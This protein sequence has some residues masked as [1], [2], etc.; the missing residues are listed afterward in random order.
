M[1]FFSIGYSL[2]K[3]LPFLHAKYWQMTALT[4]IVCTLFLAFVRPLDYGI[5]EARPIQAYADGAFQLTQTPASSWEVVDAFPNLTFID[6]V[7]I[8]QLEGTNKLWILGKTGFIWSVD[9]SPAVT[10][11]D[12]VMDITDLVDAREDAGLLGLA[13]HPEFSNADS[14]SK[15][16]IYV[17]YR[18]LPFT[19][20]DYTG[21]Q[22]YIRVSRFTYDDVTQTADPD[23]ELRLMNI[24]DRHDWH[25]GGGMFFGKDGFLY[26]SIGDEGGSR[27]GFNS[28]QKIDQSLFS[29][30]LR[31]DVDKDPTRSHPIRRQPQDVKI[32]FDWPVSSTQEYYIPNDN[33]W[34]SPDSSNL[35]EFYAIGLRS[36]FRMTYDPVEELIWIG[37]VGQGKREEV[38]IIRKGDNLQWPFR[39]GFLES[40]FAEKPENLL[41]QEHGPLYQYDRSI[42]TCVIGG[43]VYRGSK[44][45]SLQGKYIFGDH[46]NRKVWSMTYG[47][48][49]VPEI[50]TLT[51][52]PAGGEGDKSGIS[53]FGTDQNG[54]IYVLKLFG[55]NKDG[56]KV[57]KLQQAQDWEINAPQ[58]LAATGIFKDFDTMEPIS[59]FIPYDVNIPFWSD[60][61]EKNRWVAIP[62]NGT[63]NA[64]TERIV[65]NGDDGWVFP[66]G[67]VFIK[68]FELPIDKRNPSLTQKL[69]TRFMVVGPDQT[70]KGF[71]YKWNQAG[72]DAILLTDKVTQD[73]LITGE[74]G[75]PWVQTWEYPS[76][77]ACLTC[78]NSQAGYV[79]GFNTPQLNKAIQYPNSGIEDNQL[80]ALNFLGMFTNPLN[81][82]QIDNLSKWHPLT[83]ATIDTAER[84]SMYLNVNC[85]YC[86][87]PN[88]QFSALD[89]R[90]NR[91][92]QDLVGLPT[93]SNSSPEGAVVI[94]SGKPESSQ[95][96]LR[97][98]SREELKMPPLGS[99]VMDSSFVSLLGDWIT[100][101]ETQ[102]N[103][104]TTEKPSPGPGGPA[105]VVAYWSFNDG[106][107][108]DRAGSFTD[109]IKFQALVHRKAEGKLKDAFIL[110]GSDASFTVKGSSEIPISLD[111]SDYSL[112]FWI[113][114]LEKTRRKALSGRSS[115]TI[116]K[117]NLRDRKPSPSREEISYQGIPD[118]TPTEW[119][120]ISI[121]FTSKTFTYF[122]NT[123]AISLPN[124]WSIEV[125]KA[126]NS[127]SF[128]LTGY[129]NG[130]YLDDL[131]VFNYG[132]SETK[133]QELAS[134]DPDPVFICEGGSLTQEIWW[135]LNDEFDISSI[136]FDKAPDDIW[137]T[138]QFESKTDTGDYYGTRIRGYLC[139]PVSGKYIFWIASDDNGELYLSTDNTP[140]N[141]QRI[142]HV[143]GWTFPREWDKY[144][145]QVSDTIYL[146]SGRKYYIEAVMKEVVGGD[147]MSVGWQLPNGVIERPMSIAYLSTSPEEF[148]PGGNHF[149]EVPIVPQ[150]VTD[151][152]V[153]PN[154]VKD[155]L[156]ISVPATEA[157][158]VS[159][160]LLDIQGKEVML[161]QV[162]SRIT[163]DLEPL[164]TGVYLLI[165]EG[166][167]TRE[168]RKIIK[169]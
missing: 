37:D 165:L 113:K 141:K 151:W 120:H 80:R 58:S 90:Y 137:E 146:E 92:L 82:N 21:P 42:G 13:L 109:E 124:N 135:N 105:G 23:S 76:R 101:L 78:H 56:G 103:T 155:L 8:F 122:Q 19:K 142:A 133:I 15:G 98:S 57:F 154:P 149:T 100:K 10:E 114:P 110:E 68:H 14:P 70:V 51:E 159:L 111:S 18:H 74:D 34:Q 131:R 12:V 84:L 95:I 161:S 118:I 5:P 6:P 7:Q 2:N 25:D 38:N 164:P 1:R 27:D 106:N 47:A 107:I 166:K 64:A 94:E 41:G 32:P 79:L 104:D 132:I 55:T 49:V 11:K 33:P 17:L 3:I 87:R 62:N 123:T 81:E 167:G 150:D 36:P 136:P 91:P 30:V 160:R 9:N 130:F 168:S 156:T 59:G 24:M 112:S 88:G 40:D 16:Y 145:Q 52:V 152:E 140:E 50:T 117:R 127:L 77:G 144:P 86:H 43:F 143:I 61:A 26:I 60:R 121:R 102:D 138:T 147:H 20:T 169:Q 89:L 126:N 69:E 97:T 125:N 162:K 31:I 67:T 83:D 4:F 65:N 139:P 158:P 128:S 54:E 22:G 72:T 29:G 116:P 39:E 71:T 53:A 134:G 93:Q 153:Y 46:V 75:Q 157:Q 85:S 163:L 44:F 28:A 99:S 35:E 96:W 45:T 73:F 115:T 63:H 108:M 48:G 66:E 148:A 129:T 119:E